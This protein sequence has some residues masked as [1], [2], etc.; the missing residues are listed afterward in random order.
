MQWKVADVVSGAYDDVITSCTIIDC[1]YPYEY[2]GG[3]IKVYS[4]VLVCLLL[5]C[6][7]SG[8]N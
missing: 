6:L 7:P 3:H 5:M 1:R 8:G 4:N 2:N